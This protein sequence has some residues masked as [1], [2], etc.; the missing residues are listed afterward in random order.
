MNNREI[1]K[2]NIVHWIEPEKEIDTEKRQRPKW[3]EKSFEVKGINGDEELFITAHGC[4][5]AYINEHRVGDFVLAPGTSEYEKELYVQRYSVADLLREGKNTIKVLLGD[6]W[7]RS[8][9]GV[10]G[11]RNLFGT[12]IGLLAWISSKA[13]IIVKTDGTWETYQHPEIVSSDMCQGEVID[14]SNTLQENRK[15]HKRAKWQ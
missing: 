9:A 14:C 15:S 5:E 4:Y 3:V 11:A 8:A 7:Y 2:S 10:T 13:S 1:L 6:G 12:H